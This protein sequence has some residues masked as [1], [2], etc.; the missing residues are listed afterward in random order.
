MYFILKI[1]FYL[2]K[3]VN[4]TFYNLYIYYLEMFVK[5]FITFKLYTILMV[6]FNYWY[7]LI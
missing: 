7:N 4:I 3:V 1:Q 2:I 6:N 5:C